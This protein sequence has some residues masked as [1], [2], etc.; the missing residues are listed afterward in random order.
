M[1]GVSVQ[2]LTGQNRPNTTPAPERGPAIAVVTAVAGSLLLILLTGYL[3]MQLV[4]SG[5]SAFMTFDSR[6][7]GILAGWLPYV[8]RLSLILLALAAVMV[9]R[10]ILRGTAGR[11]V[12]L[13]TLAAVAFI[14]TMMTTGQHPAGE[15]QSLILVIAAEGAKSPLILALIG[16]GVADL[17]ARRQPT[18][19]Q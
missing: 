7:V 13:A 6:A 16:V 10:N 15:Q 19:A 2:Q 4:M 3:T 5:M 17:V 8:W 1:G 11:I 18:R 9:H 12:A 14:G